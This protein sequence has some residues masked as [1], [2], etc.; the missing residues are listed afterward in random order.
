MT[1]IEVLLWVAI[2][3]DALLVLMS[4]Y[5]VW[6]RHYE[7]NFFIFVVSL[8]ALSFGLVF[9]FLSESK[10]LSLLRILSA[11]VFLFLNSILV[12]IVYRLL[13]IG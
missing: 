9:V 8:A 7:M 1:L 5:Q 12:F 6:Q 11:C 10:S 4:G 13:T 3:F 2:S